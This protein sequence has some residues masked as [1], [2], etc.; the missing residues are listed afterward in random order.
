VAAGLLP[1]LLTVILEKGE[2]RAVWTFVISSFFTTAVTFVAYD[3][4]SAAKSRKGATEF[5]EG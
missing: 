5:K 4:A 1:S 3:L 2:S